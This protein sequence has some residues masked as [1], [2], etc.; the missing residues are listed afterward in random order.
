LDDIPAARF[1]DGGR[2]KFGP[3]NKLYIT[4]GDAT[5]PSTAQ[6]I[7]SVSGKILRM[8]KDTTIPADNPFGNYV[9]SYG[10]RNPQGIAWNNEKNIM[11]AAEHGPIR[12]DEVN[13]IEQ[14]KNYGWPTTCDK[15]SNFE[16]PIRCYTELTLAPAGIA[17]H[18]NNLYVTGLKGAQLRK[19]SLAEDGKTIIEEDELF[20]E[21]GR[22]REVVVHDNFL[23]IATSNRDGRGIPRKGDDKIIRIKLN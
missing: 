10:H 11:Y 12:K 15:P 14:G 9:Y 23:Y 19:L 3:D 7:N 16:A 18:E 22:I 17:Y 13:V 20:S 21:L 5:V 6:D 1:H 8:N 4:T 2:I